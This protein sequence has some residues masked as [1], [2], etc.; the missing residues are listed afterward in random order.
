M[1]LSA[2][3]QKQ[4]LDSF[5]FRQVEPE[6]LESF[7][8]E[9]EVTF[10]PKGSLIYTV[11][12][13]QRSIG[14]LLS[15]TASVRKGER[16]VLNQLHPGD[17]FGVAAVF[18]ETECYVTTVE[19][20]SDVKLVYL[21]AEQLERLFY[22]NPQ[23]AVNYI[24]FLS[25]RIQFLNR[26]ID[27]FTAPNAQAN[28]SLYLLEQMG[29]DGRVTV[30]GGYSGLARQLGMGRASL[31][32]CLEELESAGVISRQEREILVHKPELLANKSCK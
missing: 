28:L 4:V 10:Y 32:R 5:L 17:C 27:S 3:Q 14:I 11:H 20:K 15:G 23:I 25:G 26:K 2:R 29:E 30:A 22:Q 12:I 31:Y 8:E 18:G 19:A 9:L 13:F 24:R 1:K 7:L 16:L 6:S 21:S